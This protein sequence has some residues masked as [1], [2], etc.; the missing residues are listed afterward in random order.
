MND[1]NKQCQRWSPTTCGP[2]L[3]VW[4][5]SVA[6]EPSG[7]GCR[8]CMERGSN[9]WNKGKK[10]AGPSE[11]HPSSICGLATAIDAGTPPVEYHHQGCGG[12]EGDVPLPQT[13]E[14]EVIALQL[15]HACFWCGRTFPIKQ[16]TLIH[17]TR[18]CTG[19]PSEQSRKGTLADIY[20]K[21]KKREDFAA[22]KPPVMLVVDALENVHK[23][24]Y[25][26][27]VL[28]GGRSTVE[29]IERLIQLATATFSALLHMWSILYCST[30]VYRLYRY[31]VLY[32]NPVYIYSG[33]PLKW[34]H[35]DIG[36]CP[37]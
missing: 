32:T 16:G 15:P 9:G 30:Y 28:C 25:L 22:V 2:V 21:R 27:S 36:F 35:W 14:Q 29:D 34:T 31:M 33:I 3:A 24:T 8:S 7:G 13:T 4:P 26:G 20:V 6:R 17:K 10:L 19:D 5:L 11:M 37:L 12:V 18:W 1:T 23:F